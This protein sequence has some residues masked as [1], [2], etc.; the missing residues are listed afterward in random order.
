MK[1]P[2]DGL[3]VNYRE[4]WDPQVF[5]KAMGCGSFTAE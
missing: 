4:Y 5:M 1:K 3:I 2:L